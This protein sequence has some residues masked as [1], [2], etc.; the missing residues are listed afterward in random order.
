MNELE[1]LELAL[2]EL[3]GKMAAAAQ[4]IILSDLTDEKSLNENL[5]KLDK[6]VGNYYNTIKLLIK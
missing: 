5:Y 6:E 4:R 3:A 1:L 2:L